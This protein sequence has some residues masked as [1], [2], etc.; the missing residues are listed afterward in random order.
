MR[1]YLDACILSMEEYKVMYIENTALHYEGTISP[2]HPYYPYNKCIILSDEKLD[3][4]SGDNQHPYFGGRESLLDK[5]QKVYVHKDCTLSRN[6]VHSQYSKTLD[7]WK[8]DAVIIPNPDYDNISSCPYTMM[9]V[10]EDRKYV[11]LSELDTD[12]VDRV[13]KNI[14]CRLGDLSTYSVP[15]YLT[16]NEAG[17][18]LLVT[19]NAAIIEGVYYSY[20]FP[21]NDTI[22]CDLYD[23]KLPMDKIVYE[24]DIVNKL[25]NETNQF[26]VDSMTSL[27]EM[28]T[29][30]DRQ[31]QA[32]GLKTLSLMDFSNYP[33]CARYILER[34]QSDVSYHLGIFSNKAKNSVAVKYMI[35]YLRNNCSYR[36]PINMY[37][38]TEISRK[39]W[40]ILNQYLVLNNRASD[41]RTWG[42]IDDNNQ[43]IFK[44]E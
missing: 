8:A 41:M 33:V 1:K 25:G 15:S 5:A 16:Y 2:L 20:R 10:C 34:G 26:T 12:I 38:I 27:I 43:P 42:F 11:I 32:L 6:V 30:G 3:Y 35:N 31:V 13:K 23:N 29:S 21:V 9:A 7:P 14:G 37:Y 40:E 44:N 17:K 39:D 24:K 36:Y 19:I 4:M 28:V 22:L 18:E